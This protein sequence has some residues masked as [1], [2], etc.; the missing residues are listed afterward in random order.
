MNSPIFQTPQEVLSEESWRLS[1][2][3]QS[4]KDKFKEKQNKLLKEIF[5]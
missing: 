2:R 3:Q 5:E 1:L 4:E